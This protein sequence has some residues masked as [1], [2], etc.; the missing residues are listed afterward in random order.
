MPILVVSS[1]APLGQYSKERQVPVTA[2]LTVPRFTES[3]QVARRL[4]V[5]LTSLHEL[6]A[7]LGVPTE[8]TVGGRRLWTEEEIAAIQRMREERQVTRQAGRETRAA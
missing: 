5:S 6:G 8:R 4:G 2:T 1:I 3:G 7:E